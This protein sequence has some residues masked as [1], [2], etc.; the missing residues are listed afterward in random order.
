MKYNARNQMNGLDLLRSISVD[1]VALGFLDPQYREV[2]D[3]LNFG[4]EGERQAKRANLPQMTPEDIATFVAEFARVLRPSGHLVLWMDKFCLA[5]GRWRRW[6]D[7]TID[8]ATVDLIAWNKLRMGMGKRTRGVMEYAVVLQKMPT[9]ASSWRDRAMRDGWTEHSDSSIHPHAKPHVLTER[10]IRATTK[11]GDL[12]CD[13]CAGGYGVLDACIAT[14]R[15][16]I[17]SDLVK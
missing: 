6:L 10:I 9:V 8:F 17:G 15:Q 7:D 16:F 12:V 4:N 11:R 3:K 5:T 13:P 2:L 14:G 1:K